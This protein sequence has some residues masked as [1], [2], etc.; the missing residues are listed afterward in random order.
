M[1]IR[2]SQTLLQSLLTVKV[3]PPVMT[4]SAQLEAEVLLPEGDEDLMERM[5]LAGQFGLGEV[6]F[7]NSVEQRKVDSL[8]RRG[9]GKPKDLDVADE[10]SDLQGYFR[11][12]RCK[13][14]FSILG[15]IW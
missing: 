15:F 6:H 9:Q 4:G 5:Q 3:N 10:V 2:F 14:T 7:T 13:S 8:S 12:E 11:L 1:E